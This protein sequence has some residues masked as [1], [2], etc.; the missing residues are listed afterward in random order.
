MNSD[1]TNIQQLTNNYYLDN[2]PR[3]SPDGTRLVFT[4][5][6]HQ[7]NK[8]EIYVMNADGS[9]TSRVT[10]SPTNVTGINPVWRPEQ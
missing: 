5:D 6:R 3:W 2:Y 9:G 4:S 7:A 10:Y 1:G 8:W